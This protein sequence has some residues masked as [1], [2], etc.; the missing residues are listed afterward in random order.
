MAAPTPG[1][2]SRISFA[3]ET[4]SQVEKASSGRLYPS[5]TNPNWLVLRARRVIFARWL[6]QIPGATLTILDVGGRLQP[7][8]SLLGNRCGRYVSIDL[9]VTPLVEVAADAECLPFGSA[10]FDVAICTQMLE[11][12]ADPAIVIRE[13]HRVLKPGGFLLM[14]VPSVFPRDSDEEYWR[15]LPHSVRRLLADFNHVE[16][17]PEGNSLVGFIRTVNVFLVTFAKPRF[18]ASLLC[19]SVVPLIN[20]LGFFVQSI[21]RSPDDRF[22]ANFSALAQK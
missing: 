10:Q 18:L 20:V 1:R 6:Q 16:V 17:A 9:C 12:I 3:S 21:V 5:L 8:R 4:L 19:Y 15:F 14:S 13:I 11:Y 22:S 2:V 7:Y